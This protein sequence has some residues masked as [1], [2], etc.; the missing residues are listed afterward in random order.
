MA[1]GRV[2]S[3]AIPISVGAASSRDENSRHAIFYR[4]WKP[5]PR[6]DTASSHLPSGIR[7][8]FGDPELEWL[9]AYADLADRGV[10]ANGLAVRRIENLRF[11]FQD[12][13]D[14]T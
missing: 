11:D 1:G 8:D 6:K 9:I 7:V 13:T 10:L 12:V 4:G 5:L 3:R 2:K 14:H